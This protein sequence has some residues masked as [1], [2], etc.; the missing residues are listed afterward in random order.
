VLTRDVDSLLASRPVERGQTLITVADTASGWDLVADVPQRQIGHV[1]EAQQTEHTENLTATLRL[2]GDVQQTYEGHVVQV[3]AAAPLEPEGLENEAPP[4]KVRIA[5]DGEAPPAARPG[6]TASVRI[7][8]GR[9][10]LGYV[11]LHDVGATL[12]RWLTF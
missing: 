11:W 7:D 5:L 3:S 1:L 10:S 12:Y 9:R 4:V 2:A 8:C 6:M